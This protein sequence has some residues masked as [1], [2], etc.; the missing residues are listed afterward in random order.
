[1]LRTVV[2]LAIVLLTVVLATVR[3]TDDSALRMMRRGRVVVP[4][5]EKRNERKRVSRKDGNGNKGVG[6]IEV[7]KMNEDDE[8]GPGNTCKGGICAIDN[9]DI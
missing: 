5:V 1:M 4:I 2:I 7:Q 3:A 8:E 9:Y 6:R